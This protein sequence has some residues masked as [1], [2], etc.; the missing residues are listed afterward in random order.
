M[1]FLTI[2]IACCVALTS[3]SPSKHVTLVELKNNLPSAHVE[4]I[5]DTDRYFVE[6]PNSNKRW[7]VEIYGW[8]SY[9]VSFLGVEPPILR[10]CID[11]DK[12]ATILN[13]TQVAKPEK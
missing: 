7:I 4:Q 2:L 6:D 8:Q 10:K 9:N 11:R 13:Q 3:C 12:I 1:K 5:D